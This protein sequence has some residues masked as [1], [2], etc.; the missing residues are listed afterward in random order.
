[1]AVTPVDLTGF[2]EEQ[3]RLFNQA[4]SL[5]SGVPTIDSA[6]DFGAGGKGEFQEN[7][8]ATDFNYDDPRNSFEPQ[9]PGES[10]D[11][12][13]QRL[14]DRPFYFANYSSAGDP[15]ALG[16]ENAISKIPN[17]NAKTNQLP[18]YDMSY[19]GGE[20]EE[21]GFGEDVDIEGLIG[22]GDEDK[23]KKKKKEY[24]EQYGSREGTNVPMPQ[25]YWETVY[26]AD[27]PIFREI[28]DM[29]KTS[30]RV[31]QE[32]VAMIQS[33]FTARRAEQQAI[34][35]R[36]LKGIR[37][38]L[39]LG[40][41]SRYAPNVA[42]GIM[43]AAETEA[44]SR[45]T[46]LD[47]QE[48][49]AIAEART[50]QQNQDYQL[51]E[52]KLDLLEKI[53]GEK[54]GALS[55]A[56]DAMEKTKAQI[57]KENAMSELIAQGITDP[58]KIFQ[59]L[60]K[61]GVQ[62]SIKEVGEALKNFG[63]KASETGA[64]KFE[65]KQV[66]PLL[67]MGFTLQDIQDMQND[68]NSGRSIESILQGVPGEMQQAVRDALGVPANMSTN[69][70]P[71][72][73]AKDAITEQMI[74]TRLFPKAA[75]ILNKGTLSDADRKIIDER[76]GFFRDSGLSE[77]QIL[78]VFSGWSADVSTPFNDSFRNTLL[79][80]Q[81]TGEGVSQAL[82]SLGSLLAAGNY[83]GAMNKVENVA[84]ESVKS[85]DGYVGKIVTEN[86]TKKIDR[87]KQLLKQ[88]GAWDGMG[89]IE[90]T[91]QNLL[92][93]VKG[94]EATRIKGELAALYADFRKENAGT[95]TTQSE[96]KFLDPL[97]ATIT[98]T[99]GNFGEKLDVFQRSILDGHNAT[100]RT[101]SLPEVRVQDILDPNERLRLYMTQE[102][103]R[104]APSLDI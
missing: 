56:Q 24:Q 61:Q 30:D 21:G 34:N 31:A 43:S 69:V 47:T 32:Q 18:F 50:A 6:Q 49:A 86:Y 104:N 101:V 84:L 81:D 70:K 25:D 28:A 44:L 55:E 59:A 14:A 12:Y 99:K 57:E 42:G 26:G 85:Q 51:L 102:T 62:M 19:G 3:R 41:T 22:L 15:S 17:L 45:L 63:T 73:G 72:V 5:G 40:G 79:A 95:A 77:Q 29:R 103:S 35:E 80:T 64:F 68:F 67:G 9:R 53:R 71:G 36:G 97:F 94:K 54:S 89:P 65:N 98:D 10:D 88:G 96:L 74:R 93:R 100:R 83:R 78:D 13:R 58:L 27:A 2:T 16:S 11:A 48:R 92:K 52:S 38:V 4:A 87:I 90:G 39:S 20:N 23:K 75:S 66:G 76:I 8:D 7:V 46:K 37:Q 33:Q 60:N 91:F 1:M 82:T